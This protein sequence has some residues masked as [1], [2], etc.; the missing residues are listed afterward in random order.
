MLY[1]ALAFLIVGQIA[2]V[3]GLAGIASVAS[4]IAWVLFLIGIVL[5]VN[6]SDQGTASARHPGSAGSSEPPSSYQ[7]LESD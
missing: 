2:G 4:Q 3:L 7:P 1:S 6:P 5:L